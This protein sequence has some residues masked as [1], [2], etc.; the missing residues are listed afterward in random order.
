MTDPST[1]RCYL[2]WIE[3]EVG[4]QQ[5][6]ELCQAHLFDIDLADWLSLTAEA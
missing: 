5:D 4:E 2:E 6:A 3:P 1:G